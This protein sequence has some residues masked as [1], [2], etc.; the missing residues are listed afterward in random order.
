MIGCEVDIFL[1]PCSILTQWNSVYEPQIGFESDLL[2]PELSNNLVIFNRKSITSAAMNVS[3]KIRT[4]FRDAFKDAAFLSSEL[5]L[6]CRMSSVGFRQVH[7]LTLKP[8]LRF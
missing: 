8:G 3:T 2:K 6:S 7:L 4:T 5:A 1:K